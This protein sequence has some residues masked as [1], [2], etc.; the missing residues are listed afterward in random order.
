MDHKEVTQNQRSGR[1]WVTKL[2][3]P[4]QTETERA[5]RNHAKH[6]DGSRRDFSM[7]DSAPS[8]PYTHSVKSQRSA[9]HEEEGCSRVYYTAA[10]TS[11]W[12]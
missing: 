6:D 1:F 4:T 12:T 11:L 7:L 8:K 2:S 5:P 10:Y 9:A 3:K